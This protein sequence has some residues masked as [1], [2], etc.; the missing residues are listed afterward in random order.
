MLPYYHAN[1]KK[2]RWGSRQE[3]TALWATAKY[4]RGKTKAVSRKL[5]TKAWKKTECGCSE[6]TSHTANRWCSLVPTSSVLRDMQ[7]SSC[8]SVSISWLGFAD[9]RE[10]EERLSGPLSVVL[11]QPTAP[12][13][14]AAHEGFGSAERSLVPWYHRHKLLWTCRNEQATPME[15]GNGKT[16]PGTSVDFT[17]LHYFLFFESTVIFLIAD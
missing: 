6:E 13:A 5:N 8:P 17:W 7:R 3:T 2:Q 11:K 14:D 15:S 1:G 4:R 16:L 9:V 12:R 10:Q